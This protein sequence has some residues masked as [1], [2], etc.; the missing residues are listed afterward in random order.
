MGLW[1]KQSTNLTV[2]IGPFIDDS[3][4]KTAET[5]LTLTQADIRLSKNGGNMA[6]KHEANDATHDEIGYYDCPIDTTD[7]DTLGTLQLMVHQA[8][9]LPVFHEYMVLP[10]NVYDS[11][12]STDKLQ[13]DL[14]EI[15]DPNLALTTQMKADVNAE[16]DAALDTAIPGSPTFNSIN[17]I[18]SALSDR[19]PANYIMGSSVNTDLD[20]TINTID[21]KVDNV[22]IDVTAIKAVTDTL[23]LVAIADA[24]HDEVVE[25]TTTLRQAIRLVNAAL[26]GKL[27]GGGTNTLTFRDVG[28]IKDRITAT[29]DANKNRTGIVL[30]SS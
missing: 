10:A 7:T 14:R 25:G 21:G 30:D 15:G 5:G 23:T 11:L 6:Q 13:I 17:E 18:A 16:V 1:L 27:S 8:G 24:V 2:K 19:L 22:Q 28:D 20:G 9:S 3:D 12:V 26:F 4:G 29:V